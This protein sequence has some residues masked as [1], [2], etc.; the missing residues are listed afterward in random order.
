MFRFNNGILITNDNCI[1]CNYCIS[2]C[3]IMGANISAT[4]DGKKIIA[5]D[6]DKCNHCGKCIT[7]CIHE[8][9]EYVDDIDSFYNDLQNGEKISLIVDPSFYFTF[10]DNAEKILQY[11]H[12][13]GVQKIYDSTFGSE[14]S[15]WGTVK[16][17]KDNYDKPAKEKAFIV[18]NCP[19]FINVVEMKYPQLISKVIPIQSG[20]LCTAIYVHKYLEDTNKL[21]YLGPCIA[22]KD[23][24]ETKNTNGNINYNLTYHHIWQK[25]KDVDF[26]RFEPYKS[27]LDSIGFGRFAIRTGFYKTLIARFFSVKDTTMVHSGAGDPTFK[28]ILMYAESDYDNIQPLLCEVYACQ[29]GCF[30]GPGTETS[31]YRKGENF[32]RF[33]KDFKE[34]FESF[35]EQTTDY[36]ESTKFLFDKFKDFDI[37]DFKRNF[38]ERYI[39]PYHIS[40]SV[41]DDIFN[42]M[43]KN[44]EEKR[45]IDCGMCGYKTCKSMAT[46]IA[47]SYN[48]KENCIH[49]MNDEMRHRLYTDT[50]ANCPNKEAF[51]EKVSSVI[52]QNPKKK[53]RL[54]CGDIN[55]Y[56]V[57]NELFGSDIGDA[58]LRTISQKLGELLD[59]N[60]WYAR[61][62][63]GQFAFFIEE[64]I[65]NIQKIN[66]LKSFDCTS[67]GIN[68]PITMRFG[69]YSM[70]DNPDEKDISV[71]NMINSAILAMDLRVTQQE[72]TYNGY[73][74][75]LKKKQHDEAKLSTL[76]KSALDNNEFVLW[77]QPQ[78]STSSN[79]L[80]GAE[81]LCRWINKEG[82]II[83]PSIFIPVTE[84]NGFIRYLDKEIWRKA[85]SMVRRWI[86]AG[87]DP[88]P[89]SINISRVSLE[90]DGIYYTI[91]YL[92]D[93][94]HIPPELIHFEITESAY[95]GDEGNFLQRINQIRSLGFK[96]AMDDFGSGYSSLNSLKDIPIDIIKLDMGFLNDT[97]NLSKIAEQE[98]DP[99]HIL[100]GSSSIVDRGGTII[101][102]VI[103]MAQKLKYIT[104]AEGVEKEEQVQFLKS[105][106]CD[107]I[108]GFL[109]A[110][111]MPEDAFIKILK[112]K[113]KEK[114]IEIKTER[115]EGQFQIARF[116]NPTTQESYIFDHFVGAAI[117][118]EYN[119][120]K[121][122]TTIMRTNNQ[123]KEL[124][125]VA[126]RPF[127]VINN[128]FSRF[129]RSKNGKQFKAA[130]EKATQTF[131]EAKCEV[132]IHNLSKHDV[133]HIRSHIWQITTN[134]QN[135]VFYIL[136]EDISE[137]RLLEESINKE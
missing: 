45:H 110:K 106:G 14:I 65:E 32:S 120:A 121:A 54:Y 11:F 7:L 64:T 44:T 109:Y 73:T 88:V 75:A 105:I 15:L 132:R 112:E 70:Q 117:I 76:M 103:R 39:Q 68:Y 10:G 116:I 95:I 113:D 12:S 60:G 56:K 69:Y 13:I 3:S 9:R 82:Q 23:E 123:A 25:I 36:K 126:D 92:K 129:I 35:G 61:I 89:V 84:K 136:F 93:E 40:D 107:I 34:Y 66:N 16:Y 128:L 130:L 115:P 101:S 80:V 53:Y 5:I 90:S 24:I 114:Q 77:F 124:F 118:I 100:D 4:R 72:N 91:K 43:L 17:L 33:L 78:Y 108:Q 41:Y 104:V 79:K 122:H 98:E 1:G 37:Q 42:A 94:Y 96:I 85:F 97:T 67:L 20:P 102:S 30:E 59:G 74:K 71:M 29:Q 137:Y 50:V 52:T 58:V 51:I 21:A 135:Y 111:P 8:A 99:S 87:Y 131:D 55:K 83:S 18:N 38:T 48:K 6:S 19:A 57:I 127:D 2:Q 22:K 81:A 63:S 86:D 26:S 27:D 49:Y 125:G 31:V 47:Y 134:K 28:R 133:K 62:T 119:V 46:A